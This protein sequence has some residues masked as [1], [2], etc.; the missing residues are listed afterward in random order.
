MEG[1]PFR[2]PDEDSESPGREIPSPFLA[3]SVEP[4]NG[5]NADIQREVVKVTL[6]ITVAVAIKF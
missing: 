3:E 6:R 5:A 1:Q 2:L 4:F